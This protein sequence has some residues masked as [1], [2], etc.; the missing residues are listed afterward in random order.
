MRGPFILLCVMSAIAAAGPGRDPTVVRKDL[1]EC[2]RRLDDTR[3]Q[4]VYVDQLAVDAHANKV[5]LVE[6]KYPMS[7]DALTHAITVM[8]LRGD[9]LA[10]S[11]LA[12]MPKYLADQHART[13]QALGDIAKDLAADRDRTSARCGSL[14]AELKEA[15]R[16]PPPPPDT[17]VL[18]TI[19]LESAMQTRNLKT[20]VTTAREHSPATTVSLPSGTAYNGAVT[21]S[22]PL[23]DGYT[24]YIYYHS[25]IWAV[26][27]PTGGAFTVRENV[28]FSSWNDVEAHAC[29]TGGQVGGQLA[30]PCLGGAGTSIDIQ[31]RQ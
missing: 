7:P 29:H 23:P 3:A 22:A 9:D 28:G 19:T 4:I 17:G 10:R 16:P 30:P 13:L 27:G 1:D 26:L 20:G 25:Q 11:A 14:A 12:D 24:I 6:N 5:L 8:A 21:T 2:R 31:W 15:Q 18:M